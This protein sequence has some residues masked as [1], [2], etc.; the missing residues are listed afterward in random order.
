MSHFLLLIQHDSS[1]AARVQAALTNSGEGSFR[2]EWVGS[3]SEGLAR[4]AA[5]A[6][7]GPDR[8]AAIVVD[9]FLPD[10]QGIETFGR[11]FHAA[12]HI[13]ILILS[14][15]QHADVARL[16]VQQGGHDYLLLDRVDSYLLPKTLGSMFERAA[17]AEALFEE[18]ER[19]QITLNSIGDA[20]MSSDINGN[21]TYL[22]LAGERLTGWSRAEAAGRPF[23]EVL[24]IIDAVTGLVAP[25]P[26]AR[27]IRENK[28]VT[29]AAHRILLRRDGDEASIEGSAAPIHDRRGRV[30]GA[31]MVF[32]DVGVTRALAQRM[33][34]LAQHDSLTDLPN[35]ALLN[36]RL[37]QAISRAHRHRQRLAVLFLD[38]DRFKHINDSLGHDVGDNLL[39][40]VATRLFKCVRTSDTVSRQGGDEFVVLLSEVKHARDA[41]VSAAKIILALNQP[42]YIDKHKLHL[43]VSIGIVVYPEDGTDGETLLKHADFAMYHA[44]EKGRDNYQFFQPDMNA[45]A[46]ERQSVEGDLRGAI[47]RREFVLHYQPRVN[48]ETGAIIGVEALIRWRHPHRGLVQPTRFVPIAEDCG[49]IVPIGRWVLR[50]ACRQA[51]AW[52]V[53]SLPPILISI[54]ISAVELRDKDFISGVREALV[55]TG[56]ASSNL[57][58]ELTETF[59]MQ[60][61]KSTATVLQAL[62]GLGVQLALDDFGTGFSSL[63]HLKSFP[64]DT[65]KIDQSFVRNLT[66][67][68]G[69]AGIVTAVINMGRTLNV[70]VVAEGVETEE[71]LAFL[72]GQ[73]C[74]EWQGYYFSHPV[75]AQK[76]GR[77]LRRNVTEPRPPDGRNGMET[78]LQNVSVGTSDAPP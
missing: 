8:I 66:T 25:N 28:T 77:L 61:S 78:N 42:H 39:R 18:K 13:P 26:M 59:L 17:I 15:P 58:L 44:K 21:V 41:A 70:Q 9:L 75:S 57:E 5:D 31:V 1:D 10:S 19:A 24:R 23:E 64:I 56:L 35:R 14:A 63:S 40:S 68:A 36:D 71:Q 47:E 6:G 20:V 54:N 33:S 22:N 2:V 27:A 52:Q 69:D 53:E 73:G 29:L 3:C 4:L 34:H 16:A 50:E 12:P 67:D 65:L 45:R 72:R 51:R 76:F 49:V 74:P 62:K 32:H 60:D 43:T 37:A 55:E 46:Q 48:L 30:T 11:L 7:D 38:L